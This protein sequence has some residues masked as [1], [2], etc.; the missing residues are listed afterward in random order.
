MRAFELALKRNDSPHL[1]R[2]M[3]LVARKGLYNVWMFE[4]PLQPTFSQNL[5]KI[6]ISAP[7][8]LS[9][10][11][12][13]MVYARIKGSP[14][15]APQYQKYYGCRKVFLQ[16]ATRRF[17]EKYSEGTLQ[18]MFERAR[19]ER[20]QKTTKASVKIIYAAS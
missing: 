3:E 2:R 14:R 15:D 11:E 4:E 17:E 8:E 7:V 1:E 16:N 10:V 18:R 12:A 5:E 19:L 9:C 20:R 13:Y 6:C